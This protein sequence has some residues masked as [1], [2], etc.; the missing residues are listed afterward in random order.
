MLKII[1]T[2]ACGLIGSEVTKY[3]I[4]RKNKVVSCDYKLG[5]NLDNETF[6]KEW[7]KK[8]K[9]DYLVNLFAINDH[10]DKKRKM[11]NLFNISLFSFCNILNTN[12]TSLFSVCRQFAINNPKSGIINFASTYGMVSPYP[13]LYPKSAK[14]IGYC[15]S[16]AGV[17]QMSRY[18]AVHLAPNIRV[19]C[20]VPGGILYHQGKDFVHKYSKKTPLGRMMNVQELNGIVELLCSEKSSYI[21]GAVLNVDGGWAAW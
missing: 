4:S 16:K 12:L 10:V 9:A 21:T 11:N 18:L 13:E 6:V 20:I 8:N 3:L 1:V 2:G 5:H 19:N 15:V 7:F 17:I 14:H